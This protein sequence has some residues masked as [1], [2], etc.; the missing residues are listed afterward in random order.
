MSV[1]SHTYVEFKDRYSDETAKQLVFVGPVP[2]QAQVHEIVRGFEDSGSPYSLDDVLAAL[3]GDGYVFDLL[4]PT[5][6]VV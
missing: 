2:E 3:A 5:Y 1:Q 6:L 4:E